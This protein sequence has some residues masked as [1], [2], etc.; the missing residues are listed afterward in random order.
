MAVVAELRIPR[1]LLTGVRQYGREAWLERLPVEIER[2]AARWSLTLGEPFEPGGVAAWV[3]PARSPAH[4][5]VVLKVGGRHMESE[6]EADGLRAWDGN[7][8]VRVLA[9]DLRDDTM[10]LLLE[11]CV[12]GTTLAERP[13]DE[14]DVIISGLLRRLWQ[15]PTDGSRFR[16]LST[17]C[18]YWA[19]QFEQKLA[20]GRA[21]VDP[22]LARA[23]ARDFRTLPRTAAQ[24]V[25]I[26]TDLHAEN[27]LASA[28]E[29]W[30]VID[31]KP[32]VGDP[33]YDPLQ[34]LLNCEE[35]LRADP[36]GLAGRMADLL[37]L[38]HERLLRWLFARC[39]VESPTWPWALDVA[40]ELRPR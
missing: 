29:E 14:Q 6:N 32:F 25:L 1:N 28:R 40:R 31:P 24:H 12:P 10:A 9:D 5:D 27:V 7:G 36:R 20:S 34:H 11:R 16:P 19:D 17:M 4:G 39:V 30:L 26:P 13:E 33:T 23:G 21:E 22:D 18:D 8:T 2:V 35:R 38:D 37:G 15:Q 3:A